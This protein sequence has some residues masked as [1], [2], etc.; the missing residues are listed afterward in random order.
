M[1]MFGVL[2]M[3][4]LQLRLQRQ[5]PGSLPDHARGILWVSYTFARR[6]SG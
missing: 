2:T 6:L 1:F 5:Q 4:N 3:T